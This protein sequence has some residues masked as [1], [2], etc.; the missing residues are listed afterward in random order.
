MTDLKFAIRQLLKNPGFT[1]VVVVSLALGIGLNAAVFSFINTV[2]FQ[3]IQGVKQP[4]RVVLGTGR[5]S[6]PAYQ[7]LS[8]DVTTVSGFA[9]CAGVS[10]VVASDDGAWRYAVPAVS[11]SYFP[12]LGVRPFLGRFFEQHPAGTPPALPEAVLDFQFWQRR[13]NSDPAVIGRTLSLNGIPFTVVGVGPESFHG[14]GP[15]RP[16]CWVPLGMLPQLEGKP[17]V[18]S[19]AAARQFQLIGRLE[20]GATLARLRAETAMVFARQPELASEKPLDFGAGR[21][22]WTG[23][24]TTEKRAEF[25]L[26]TVV[27]LVATAT[28]LWIACS[29]VANLLL[30]RAVGRRREIAIRL[31]T[32]ASR[33]RVLRLLLLESL[34]LAIAGGGLGLLMSRWTVQF[35]FATFPEYSRL[36]VSL[37]GSVLAYT[38]A[39][40]VLST[41]FFGLV[42]ALQAT[43]VDVSTGLRSE[44][45]GGGEDWRGSR[46][47]TVFLITQI[48]CSMVLLVVTATFVRS[49]LAN[50]FGETGRQ[51]DH[52]L[53][54]RLPDAPTALTARDLQRQLRE[55]L[56]TI[57]GVARVTLLE[58]DT[59]NTA[60]FGISN[61]SVETTNAPVVSVQRIDAQYFR[62]TGAELVLGQNVV[63]TAISAGLSEAVINEAA[64]HRFWPGGKTLG[65]RF[66]LDGT[67]TL[68]VTGVVRDHNEQAEIYR[69]LPADAA[70]ALVLVQ[71]AIPADPLVSPVRG[72]L[73]E[74]VPKQSFPLVSTLRDAQVG[75]LSQMTTVS[76]LLGGLALLLAATGLYGSMSFTSSQRRREM[77]IRIALGASR[78]QVARSLILRGMK[79]A[80]IGCVIGLVLV[81]IAF[82]LLV[83][84]IFGKW[85]LDLASLSAV[86]AVFALITFVACWLPARRASRVDPVIAL[87][88]E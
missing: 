11:G 33:W 32:G 22:K 80:A 24:E 60:R 76:A 9:A 13:W 46:L 3:T 56:G 74:I 41:L 34:L 70:I 83:G 17:A 39:I 77:G 44:G 75:G 23:E 52:L 38:A 73:Q 61:G 62:A 21:E 84:L 1:A 6:Y 54:A 8:S 68:L 59:G 49:L 79:I 30:A 88:N 27:P 63:P 86:A 10:A 85:T 50:R 12:I 67:N 51:I 29:N 71:T 31:A 66:V 53:V 7:A 57:P 26:V 43:R 69:P 81:V 55:R 40:S 36:A 87:R 72:G 4:L 42:P 58:S 37:D 28:I 20:T 45:A 25:L 5:I 2:F 47:R 35:V 82:Q 16:P 15:E 19:A 65:Q 78:G 48:A 64:A 18:W 14:A